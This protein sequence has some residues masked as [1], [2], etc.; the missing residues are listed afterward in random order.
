MTIRNSDEPT[1]VSFHN[2]RF[3]LNYE[4]MGRHVMYMQNGDRISLEEMIIEGRSENGGLTNLSQANP[5]WYSVQIKVAHTV[6]VCPYIPGYKL[7]SGYNPQN[8][9]TLYALFS[10]FHKVQS[11]YQA[12]YREA[13]EILRRLK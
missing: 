1:S 10:E 12:F 11:I 9:Q 5:Y 3:I 13:P 2:C 7:V 8:F 6:S 4:K